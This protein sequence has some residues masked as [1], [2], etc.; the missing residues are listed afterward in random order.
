M[1][2]CFKRLALTGASTCVIGVAALAA[3][4]SAETAAGADASAAA[5]AE[6]SAAAGAEAS[7]S[8]DGGT[9]LTEV[10]V[11][12]QKRSENL[13]KVPISTSVLD[14]QD[15]EDRHIQSLDD[16]IAGGIPSLRIVPYASR[17]FN[18]IL[19]MRGVGVMQDTNQPARDE[20]VGVYVD[21][22]YLGR[23]QGLDAALYDIDN[24]EVLKGPQGTLFGR[25]TEAGALDITTKKPTGE[26]HF[27]VTGGV[28]NYGSYETVFHLDLPEWHNISIKVDGIDTSRGPTVQNPLPGASGF[29]EFDR[30]GV[31]LQVQW[32]PTP[33]FTANY[34][35]DTSYDAATTIFS[36]TVQ[37]GTSP[38]A[39]VLP[40]LPNRVSVSP[41][42]VPE[43][44]SIGLQSGH[45]LNLIW[46][47]TPNLTIKSIS[48]YRTLNQTQFDNSA[49]D[50][51]V[52][53]P[54]GPFS[55]YSLAE[56]GQYQLSQEIQAIGETSQLKY[57]VGAIYYDEHVH[58]QAQAFNS[59]QFNAN[60][61]AATVIQY[62]P[63]NLVNNYG[64]PITD[65]V[66]P[67]FP[68][69]GVDRASRV[70]TQSYGVYGQATWTPHILGDIFHLTGGLRWTDDVKN[71]ELY[72]TNNTLPINEEGVSGAI[73][74]SKNWS[75]VDPMVNLAAD[76]T[77]DVQVYAKWGTGYKSGGAN[78]RSLDYLA[79]NPE[80]ISMEEIGAKSE[81]WDHRARLNIAAYAGAYTNIQ[82][83]FS[84]PYY[85]FGA[86]G[87]PLPGS[88]TRTTTNTFNAPGVG[89]VNGVEVDGALNPLAGLTLSGS[90]AYNYVHIPATVN[91]YPTYIPGV[92]EVINTTPVALNQVF[93]PLDSFSGAIDY[94]T[95][96]QNYTLRAHLDGNWDS[97]SYSSD[98]A[99][100]A[101]GVPQIRSQPGV[102]FNSRISLGGIKVASSNATL[103]LSFW[104]RNLFDEQHLYIRSY[105]IT[106]GIQGTYNDPRTFGFEGNMSF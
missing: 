86:N 62:G 83:D 33:N 14:N 99:Y 58:D 64:L 98:L 44:P 88:T 1:K 51:S 82:V 78:S 65:A 105:S 76:V 60:G 3:P 73:G 8:A 84:A 32:Q 12:A 30:R 104:V 96:L 59:M 90:Y 31:R 97:G 19:S 9:G 28:G 52:Y 103:T 74:L 49:V 6:A 2:I 69:A 10:I 81:F 89:H 5:G 77:Q 4:A 70:R 57:V 94:Q 47:A 50:E 79:F 71:G 80:E 106:S 16:L 42:G 91:P 93:T 92:G 46:Q 68:Y 37:A 63:D 67:L 61:T 20:G 13:Q 24:L 43:Q 56:F 34:S 72:L 35:F 75:R 95:E 87:Q 85:T 18:L 17:P 15:L 54:D 66:T 39:P 11:T 41:V 7:G 53:V 38:I 102:V 23:P 55:R 45:A 27:D 25:N 36:Q 101:P 21:G 29:G 22:V 48:A 100:V 40:V 26:F